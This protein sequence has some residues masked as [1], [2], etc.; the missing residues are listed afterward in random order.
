[1]KRHLL[2]MASAETPSERA[3]SPT[4]SSSSSNSN[5][6]GPD[7]TSLASISRNVFSRDATPAGQR[8]MQYPKLFVLGATGPTG[9]E[10]CKIALAQDYQITAY[11][12]NPQ[13]VSREFSENK[14]FMIQEGKFKLSE[15]KVSGK[16]KDREKDEKASKE[17]LSEDIKTL[18]QHLEGHAAVISCLGAHGTSMFNL[19]NLY[20]TTMQAIL[21]AMQASSVRRLI[22]ITS[23]LTQQDKKDKVPFVINYLAKPLL[24][25][26]FIDD[27]GAMEK[28]VIDFANTQPS[29][30]DFTIVRPPGL[31][32]DERSTKRVIA[33]EG[34][35]LEE[36]AW[37][38]PR[39]NVAQFILDILENNEWINK[40]VAVGMAK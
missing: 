21:P 35:L 5:S 31:T 34:N 30:I 22:C 9:I 32:N 23:W 3:S 15:L 37:G 6:F 2:T 12:R 7:P 29:P 27:M 20:T 28:M 39:V 1:L 18:T 8:M 17:A 38:M 40:P 36:A 16:E 13:R 10:F 11:V 24:M 4:P 14:N 26:G 19:T 33:R 25:K